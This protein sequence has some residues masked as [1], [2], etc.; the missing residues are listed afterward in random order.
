MLQRNDIVQVVDL[1]GVGEHYM[2]KIPILDFIYLSTVFTYHC[3]DHNLTSPVYFA[4]EDADTL[5]SIFRD[6]E[7]Q[8]ECMSVYAENRF[9]RLTFN[10]AFVSQ[11][12]HNGKG[13]MSHKLSRC[14]TLAATVS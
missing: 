11:W 3:L 1:P 5:D 2:G 9:T 7:P 10:Q 4:S 13:L 14:S 6:K 8:L 12:L